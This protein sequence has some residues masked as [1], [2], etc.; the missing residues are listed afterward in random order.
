MGTLGWLLVV[1]AVAAAAV[2]WRW[3]Q[4][5]GAWRY[6]FEARYADHRRDLGTHRSHL[7]AVRR[8]SRRTV[9]TARDGAARAAAAHRSRVVAAQAEV[10]RL[11]DPGRGTE[12]ET[13]GS[14]RLFEHKLVLT[15]NGR[16]ADHAL[17][18]VLLHADHTAGASHLHLVLPDG[19]QRELPFAHSEFAEEKIR[20]FVIAARDGVA[21]AK[22]ARLER[23][24]KLPAAEAA[25]TEVRADT[26]EVD[27][28]R[29][30]LDEIRAEQDADPAIAEA[31]QAFEAACGRW[32][33]LTGTRPLRPRAAR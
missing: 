1:A 8:A 2:L 24:A 14:L 28:A 26:A 12:G 27:R 9:S 20:A 19:A 15:T 23:E 13:L 17:D 33:K 16:A 6:A 10:D 30:R 4:Y 22:T 7:C 31:E 29:E 25:L 21:R 11:R 32:Q 18:A 3:L 5:P